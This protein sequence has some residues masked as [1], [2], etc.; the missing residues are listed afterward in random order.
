MTWFGYIAVV[1]V[2]VSF[3]GNWR[4]LSSIRTVQVID[5]VRISK[6][7][8]RTMSAGIWAGFALNVLFL[9]GILFVG[10]GTPF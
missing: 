4:Q 3:Y 8:K 2:F 6:Q 5:G 9:L 10:T 1:I 7:V